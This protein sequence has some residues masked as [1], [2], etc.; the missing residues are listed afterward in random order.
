MRLKGFII[1]CL[2]ALCSV[3]QAVAAGGLSYVYIQ[4]DKQTPFYVKL[5]GEMQPRY[6]KNYCIIPKL[7]PGPIKVEILFQQNAYPAETFTITVPAFG[8]RGFMLIKKEGVFALYD[9]QQAFYLMPG[10]AE[11]DDVV[12]VFRQPVAQANTEPAPV[13]KT[14]TPKP[15]TPKPV[16]IT[17]KPEPKPRPTT[18]TTPEKPANGEPDFIPNIEMNPDRTVNSDTALIATSAPA[19]TTPT[20]ANSD[21]PRPLPRSDFEDVLKRAKSKSDNNRLKYLLEQTDKCYSSIQ[22]RLLTRSLAT[23]PERY[24]FLKEIY[25]RVTDQANFPSLESAIT[26][27]EWK[28]YFRLILE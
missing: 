23:D 24:A 27:K 4:G 28:G 18:K 22:V 9:L 15:V 21:C 3:H 13:P 19:T 8:S 6:G 7:A 14:V 11:E 26:S 16:T 10:N 25:P 12:P 5:E 2:L 17:K 1:T 20:V